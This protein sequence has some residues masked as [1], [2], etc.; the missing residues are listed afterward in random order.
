M[1]AVNRF[2]ILSSFLSLTL[3][4]SFSFVF[5]Q[6]AWESYDPHTVAIV[7]LFSDGKLMEKYEAVADGRLEGQCYKF[8][9]RKDTKKV[10]VMVCGTFVVEKIK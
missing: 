8:P 3:P 5:A 2:F 1:F 9:I 4:F 6:D 7:K 10:E